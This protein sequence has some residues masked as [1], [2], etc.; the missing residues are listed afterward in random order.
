MDIDQSTGRPTTRCLCWG[1]RS[2]VASGTIPEPAELLQS[3]R[4]GRVSLPPKA[5]SPI[6]TYLNSSARRSVARSVGPPSSPLG[7]SNG[8][9]PT[10]ATS[11]PLGKNPA[12]RLLKFSPERPRQSVE[13]FAQSPTVS[14]SNKP[15]TASV[16]GRGKGRGRGKRVFDLTGRVTDYDDSQTNG[17]RAESLLSSDAH[18]HTSML[19]AG[20]D[21]PMTNSNLDDTMEI[22]QT[23]YQPQVDEEDQVQTMPPP[24]TSSAK[25][26]KT[27]RGRAS[28]PKTI[29]HNE[30]QMSVS[31]TEPPRRGR[32]PRKPQVY[33]DP[34]ANSPV[35]PSPGTNINNTGSLAPRDPNAKSKTAKNIHG[36]APSRAGSIAAV[37]RFVQRSETPANDSGALITRYG[38]QS[39]KPLAS[40]RGEKTV[41]GHRTLDAF[42]GIQEVIRVDEIVEPRPKQRS[43]KGHYRA[44]PRLADV[45]EEE[46]TEEK[47]AWE[48]DPGIMAA[49]VMEWDASN[50]KYDEDNTREEGT[51][52]LP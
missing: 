24:A 43:R 50:S 28:K 31:G 10:R 46:V 27:T 47:A 17:M 51:I 32:P 44:R 33:Q 26:T 18:N 6:K 29:E 11:H 30:S 38:R 3:T 49:Q 20:D 15:T 5:I 13:R 45:E 1:K 4:T 21:E 52:F 39:I 42:P 14:E 19:P 16:S 2:N 36:K 8:V 40:W 35:P 34:D 7:N 37:P 41:M 9:T 22:D 48:L 23:S 25:E 12:N